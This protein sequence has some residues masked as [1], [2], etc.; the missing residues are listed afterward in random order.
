MH[1]TIWQLDDPNP[2]QKTTEKFR[3]G[4]NEAKK[5]AKIGKKKGF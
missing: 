5:M 3:K 2:S 1:N 4:R